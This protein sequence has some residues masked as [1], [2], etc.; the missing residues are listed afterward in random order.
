MEGYRS[1]NENRV[2]ALVVDNPLDRKGFNATDAFSP[3]P[4]RQILLSFS[5]F[6]AVSILLSSPNKIANM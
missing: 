2:V 6:Q 4:T 5:S 3:P 1:H